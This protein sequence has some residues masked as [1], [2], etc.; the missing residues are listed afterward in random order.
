MKQFNIVMLRTV[1]VLNWKDRLKGFAKIEDGIMN[2]KVYPTPVDHLR[3]MP[4]TYSK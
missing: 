2:R 3:S 4:I 1:G